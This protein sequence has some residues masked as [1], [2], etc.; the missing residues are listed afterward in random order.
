VP[1]RAWVFYSVLRV[2]L[3]RLSTYSPLIPTGID[4]VPRLGRTGTPHHRDGPN[5]DPSDQRPE[6]EDRHTGQDGTKV[7]TAKP[8]RLASARTVRLLSG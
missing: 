4:V 7:V 8:G 2:E 6:G 3:D 5:Q 1:G